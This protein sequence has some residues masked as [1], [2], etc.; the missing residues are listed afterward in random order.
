MEVIAMNTNEQMMS[1]MDE[2]DLHMLEILKTDGRIS[3]LE[4]ADRVGLSPTPCSRR[5]RRLESEGIIATYHA[6]LGPEATGL[7][8][9]CQLLGTGRYT[10]QLS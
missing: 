5:L 1:T 10:E 6:A 7:E 3:V 4:L 8:P 9:V 2:I